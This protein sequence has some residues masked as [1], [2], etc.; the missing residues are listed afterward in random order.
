MKS[1]CLILLLAVMTTPACSRFTAGGRQERAYAKYQKQLRAPRESRLAKLPRY[2]TAGG[3]Q[4]RAYAKYQKKL[5]VTRERRL[6]KLH[7]GGSKKPP[8]E[9]MTSTEP[10][11]TTEIS[12]SPLAVPS[13]LNGE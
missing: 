13:D 3:R 11:E 9:V 12:E 5:R 4:E 1:L 8:A 7:R 10:Q 2:F 6:A